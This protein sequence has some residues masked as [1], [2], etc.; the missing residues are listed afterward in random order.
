MSVI[1]KVTNHFENQSSKIINVPEWNE[2]FIVKP[3][4]LDEQR[5]LIE[6]TDNNKIGAIVDLLIMKLL[7]ED[8]SKAFKLEDKQ[9][10][11]TQAD[12]VVLTNIVTQISGDS[13]IS[14]EKKS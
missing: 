7:K 5:R 14:T 1:D 12:P 11:M 4:N 13:D 9:K 3:M 6:K 2:T 8:G 10:L